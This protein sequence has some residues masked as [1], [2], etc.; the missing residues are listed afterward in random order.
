[1]LLKVNRPPL[2]VVGG[3]LMVDALFVDIFHAGVAGDTGDLV[4]GGGG[5]VGEDVPIGADEGA[6]GG[7][8]GGGGGGAAGDDGPKEDVDEERFLPGGKGG[9]IPNVDDGLGAVGIGGTARDGLALPVVVEGA[10][11][12]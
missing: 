5:L 2:S 9:G 10:L 3:S 11:G 4:I 8:G 1:M 6:G 7:G 12:S